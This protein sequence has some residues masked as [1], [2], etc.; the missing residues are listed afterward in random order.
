MLG[1]WDWVHWHVNTDLVE[2]DAGEEEMGWQHVRSAVQ[3]IGHLA[4][5]NRAVPRQVVALSQQQVR[6]CHAWAVLQQH[7]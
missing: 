4:Q 1:Q 7:L 6:L 3:H 2:I 5:G